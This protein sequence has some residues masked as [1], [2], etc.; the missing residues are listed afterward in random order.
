MAP[1]GAGR[2]ARRQDFKSVAMVTVCRRRLAVRLC[3]PGGD[4]AV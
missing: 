1:G 2:A 4:G 3:P